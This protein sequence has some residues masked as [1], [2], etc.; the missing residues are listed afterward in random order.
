MAAHHEY[1]FLSENGKY[2]P[3]QT[4][5]YVYGRMVVRKFINISESLTV[6]IIVHIFIGSIRPLEDYEISAYAQMI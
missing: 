3:M 5:Y 4:R 6:E 1:I 2:T